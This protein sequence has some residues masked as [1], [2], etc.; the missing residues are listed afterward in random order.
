LIGSPQQYR[1][2]YSDAKA[3]EEGIAT[4]LHVVK[5]LMVTTVRFFNIVGPRQSSDYGMVLPSFVSNAVLNKPLLVHGNG[6]QKRVFCHVK[7][8]VDAFA[9]LSFNDNAIGEVFN[10]GGSSE[11]SML[12]LAE[13]V[14]SLTNS[15][16]EIRLIPYKEVYPS[17]FEDMQRRVPNLDKIKKFINWE[18]KLSIE[19][20]IL[21]VISSMK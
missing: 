19:R 13:L 7:D 12:E 18:P 2:T 20:I 16:S 5:N 9:S 15:N 10:V 14:K 6:Q 8:A 11:I 17:G 3:I 1:W 21:D 4:Y